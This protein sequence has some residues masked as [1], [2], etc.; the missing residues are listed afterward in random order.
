METRSVFGRVD[1][2]LKARLVRGLRERGHTVAM[3]GDGVN[4]VLPIKRA[5]T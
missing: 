2:F 1:P 5:D 4:D 3:I